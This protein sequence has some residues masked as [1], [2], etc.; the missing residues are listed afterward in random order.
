MNKK[1][2]QRLASN[3]RILDSA[4]TEFSEKGYARAL[5]GNIAKEAG[6]SNG[7]ITQRFSGKENLYNSV[8]VDLISTY[9]EKMERESGSLN[10]MLRYI[11][12]SIKERR[13]KQESSVS[14]MTSLSAGILP[15]TLLTRSG[16]CLKRLRYAARCS[17]RWMRGG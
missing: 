6:V 4:L 9:L 14:Y 8:F 7:M 5:L 16:N 12:K 11:V 17:K 2:A 15:S 1:A 13:K 3:R 10:H